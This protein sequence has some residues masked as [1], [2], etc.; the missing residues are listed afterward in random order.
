MSFNRRILPK[1]EELVELRKS[2]E[3]DS[4]F[5]KRI[6]GKSDVIMGP[7]DSMAF[8]SEIRKE[9][10]GKKENPGARPGEHQ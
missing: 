9:I 7:S 4:E 6:I 5:I 10:D 3:S 8:I 2:F 1:L